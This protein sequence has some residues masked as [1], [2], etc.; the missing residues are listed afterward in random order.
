MKRWPRL[1]K[2]RERGQ[3]TPILRLPHLSSPSNICIISIKSNIRNISIRIYQN[4]AHLTRK[5]PSHSCT[6]TPTP[7]AH[8]AMRGFRAAGC[9]WEFSGCST[10]TILSVALRP[11]LHICTLAYRQKHKHNINP[12]T[13]AKNSCAAPRTLRW[14]L[15]VALRPSCTFAPHI[16]LT[17]VQTYLLGFHMLL[18]VLLWTM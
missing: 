2:S 11:S 9:C 15:F 18:C 6:R 16:N 4:V 17:Q 7:K 5:G 10:N 12:S 14:S 8:P 1:L 3:V 13:V